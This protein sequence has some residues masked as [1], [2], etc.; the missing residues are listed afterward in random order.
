[1][2]WY[3]I[4]QYISMTSGLSMDALHVHAGI[5]CQFAAALL[6]R[7]S[8]ASPAPWLVVLGATLAN[9][10][11]DLAFDT[12]PDRALQYGES[13]RD[14]WNTMLMPTLLLLSVRFLPRLMRAPRIIGSREEI[15]AAEPAHSSQPAE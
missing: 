11:S 12:W 10:W 7:R 14:L 2:S 15:S 4:K 9:E 6:L 5:L 13:A 8:L 3:D 1:M